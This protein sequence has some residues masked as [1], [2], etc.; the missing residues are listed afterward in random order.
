[1]A[2]TPKTKAAGDGAVGTGER[3]IRLLRFVAEHPRFS[4]KDA[5]AAI[6]LPVSTVH[7]MLQLLIRQDLVRREGP[8]DYRIS[9]EY[10]RLGGLAMQGF[11]LNG[12][13]REHLAQL[14]GRYDETCAFA[15]YLPADHRLTIV[16]MVSTSHP[17]QYRIDLFTPRTLDWGTFGRTILAHLPDADARAAL[18]DAAPSLVDG[19]PAPTLESL[20]GEMA[21]IRAEGCYVGV[22]QPALGTVGI[23][24]PVLGAGGRVVGAL[25]MTI[26]SM[27]FQAQLQPE[28]TQAIKQQ[29]GELSATLGYRAE[30]ALA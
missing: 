22:N 18:A 9:R 21:Q 28:V 23:A 5:T 3:I 10:Y 25:G 17:V 2:R 30:P 26:P 14:A 27:R 7:R 20:A 24:A 19:S 16:D 11:D 15:I 13:A 4:L 6:D 1:M 12:A 29:A 8:Q